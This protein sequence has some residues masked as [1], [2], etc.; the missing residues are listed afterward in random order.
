MS[1][2]LLRKLVIELPLDLYFPE[3]DTKRVVPVLRKGLEA[4]V[5]LEEF[6]SV[7]DECLLNDTDDGDTYWAPADGDFWRDVAM[8]TRLETLVLSDPSFI[9]RLDA[10]AEYRKHTDRPLRVVLCM[11]T[12]WIGM[13]PVVHSI[14]NDDD[15]IVRDM[16]DPEKTVVLSLHSCPIGGEDTEGERLHRYVRAAAE[17]NNLWQWQGEEIAHSTDI[18]YI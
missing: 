11:F 5:N 12:E 18:G 7:K 4:L 16:V 15:K 8:L 17:N 2:P 9:F 10:K 13:S 3:V 6:V 14:L 1:A